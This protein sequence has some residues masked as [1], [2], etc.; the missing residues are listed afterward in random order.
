MLNAAYSYYNVG[1][2]IPKLQ[3]WKD[4]LILAKN[5]NFDVFN[6]L[7]ILDNKAVFGDLTFKIG[8]GKLNYYLFNWRLEKKLEPEELAFVLM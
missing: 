4:T 8:S 6:C 2:K 7:D 5:E 3:L 1:T